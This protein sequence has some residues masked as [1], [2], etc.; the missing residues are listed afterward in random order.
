MRDYWDL[1]VD[2]WQHGFLGIDISS[3]VLAAGILLAAVVVRRLFSYFLLQQL[4]FWTRRSRSRLDDIAIDALEPPLRFIPFVIAFYLITLLVGGGAETSHVLA[5]INRSLIILVIFWALFQLV[6][7]VASLLDGTKH[8]FSKAMIEWIIKAGRMLFVALGAATVLEVWG[9][10]VGPILAG[11]GLFGVAVALGAQDLFKNLISGMF[12]IGERRFV[13]GDWIKVDGVVEGMVES[14][15]FRTTRVRQF[16]K[17]PVFVPNSKL[18]DDAVINYSRMTYRRIS[19]I[20]RVEYRTTVDQLKTICKE[21]Q[22]FLETDGDFVQPPDAPL[23][24]RVDSFNHSSIDIMIYCFT[25]SIVWGEWLVGK[26]KLACAIKESVEGCGAR[27]ALPGRSVY[28]ERLP[29]DA[30][31]SLP[32]SA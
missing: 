12:I 26:E 25:K 16:D 24:V 8:L 9:I 13:D 21:V 31:A 5:Q 10:Q 4:R 28:V 19:W 15:G 29:E 14:I 22:T 6:G 32:P 27:F 17:A 2:V 23:F 20:V 1:I 30:E 7:P 18:A 11:L 3:I